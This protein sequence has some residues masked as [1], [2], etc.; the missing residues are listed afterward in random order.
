MNKVSCNTQIIFKKKTDNIFL[1][2][3]RYTFVGGIAFLFDISILYLLTEIFKFQYLFAAGISFVIGLIVNYFLSI[4]WVFSD[5]KIENKWL[6]FVLF[7]VIG[8]IGLCLNE[9]FMWILTDIFL[10]YYLSSKIA[11]TAIIFFCNFYARKIIV[12]SKTK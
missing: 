3:F 8:F 1:Q 2:L 5:R 4:K 7:G 10:L 6:E 9:L 12:F 11:T